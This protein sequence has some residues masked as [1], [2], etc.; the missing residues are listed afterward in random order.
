MPDEREV[1][2]RLATMAESNRRGIEGLKGNLSR[3]IY[4]CQGCGTPICGDTSEWFDATCAECWA[5][6]ARI[7]DQAS[8]GG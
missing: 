1:L 7:L 2:G 8:K 4:Q 3:L 6:I 5:L